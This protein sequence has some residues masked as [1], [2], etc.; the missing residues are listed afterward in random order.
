MD[1]KDS[2]M[3][4]EGTVG[5]R[6]HVTLKFPQNLEIIWKLEG[7]ENCLHKLIICYLWYKETESTVF[8]Y[9]LLRVFTVYLSLYSMYVTVSISIGLYPNLDSW[10]ANTLHYIWKHVL[11][12]MAV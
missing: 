2:K 9:L 3:S 11:H 8:Y 5:N 4:K 7:S 1:S 12:Q 10:N 6:K